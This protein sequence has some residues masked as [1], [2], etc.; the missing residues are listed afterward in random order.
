MPSESAALAVSDFIAELGRF[1]VAVLGV[2]GLVSE[3]YGALV[4]H[5]PVGEPGDEAFPF[6]LG[7]EEELEPIRQG[8]D[9]HVHI[10]NMNLTLGDGRL[11]FASVFLARGP[12]VGTTTVLL[13]DTTEASNMH[14]QMMQQRNELDITR[15]ELE[16]A[17]ERLRERGV[18][19]EEARARA[20]DATQAKSRFLAMMTHEIRTP[21]NGVLGMLQLVDDGTLDE[22]KQE[23]LHTARGS[24]ESLLQIIGDILDFS[25]IEAG[26]LD[27]EQI[28]FD[29]RDVTRSV[30]LL[31]RPRAEEK[32]IALRQTLDEDIPP[33]VL[34]DP[35][36][37]RQILLNLIGNA[38]KFTGE[39]GVT[40]NVDRLVEPSPSLRFAVSDTG[41]GISEE[42]Q[43][44]LFQEFTQ[45]DA[46]TTRRYG[47]TGL[48]LAISKRLVELMEGEIGLDSA[49]GE[50]ST[51][52]F[53][54]PL[55]RTEALPED[56]RGEAIAAAVSGARILL[57]DDAVVNR[58]VAIAM[59]SKAGYEV[60]IAVDGREAVDRMADGG[61]DLL[62]MDLNMPEMDGLAATAE[63]RRRGI[64]IPILAMTAHSEFEAGDLS[65]FDGHLGKPVRREVLLNAV[66]AA[67]GTSG[68]VARVPGEALNESTGS[69][70]SPP[71]S[72][73]SRRPSFDREILAGFR[74]D[75]GE[76]SF[77]MLVDTYLTET[78]RR[79]DELA[80]RGDAGEI[81]VVE[82]HAHDIK[83]C[84]GTLG[85]TVLRD[86]AE[87]LEQGAHAGEI[88]AMQKLIPEVIAAALEVYPEIERERDELST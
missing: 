60:E 6:L 11:V 78:R 68:V 13:Q 65:D 66:A 45:S 75:I 46:S 2:E 41:I 81:D 1:S 55:E 22:E 36:R 28:P 54:L 29:V 34:G 87:K 80:L 38:I 16:H 33:A 25:K 10:P 43:K 32:G 40:L 52:W 84:A 37:C 85:A 58:E 71:S 23:Y 14:R 17:N 3:R 63:L 49:E 83:S 20:E 79:V 62:L 82:R 30:M 73:S 7:L 12:E 21:M 69:S 9:Q 50:G 70:D 4:D 42:A 64:S 19:L 35:V 31:L 59:L 56:R 47:G 15:R 76:E 72:S 48:G 88:G 51:F 44:R 61:Y 8:G 74:E 24:A 57:A 39:G 77:V 86:L 27:I 67:L 18:E 5:I 53:R 26:R